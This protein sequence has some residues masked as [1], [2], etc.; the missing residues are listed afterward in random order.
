MS[1]TGTGR[2]AGFE[3]GC[4]GPSAIMVAVDGSEQSMRALA[5][6][7]G[8]A[9]R[10]RSRLVAVHV[11]SLRPAL[12]AVGDR[13]GAAMETYRQVQDEIEAELR[14]LFRRSGQWGVDAVLLVAEGDPFTQLSRV[15]E[16]LHA[17]ALIIGAPATGLRQRLAGSLAV[18]L[19]RSGRRPVTVVP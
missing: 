15:A 1:W 11:R 14:A 16:E 19:V 6:A 7:V 8:L 4:D 17:D 3:L 18:R 13:T 9:R 10:Q 12:L 5:Y 2:A